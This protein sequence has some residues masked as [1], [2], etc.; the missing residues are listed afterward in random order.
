MRTVEDIMVPRN[1]IVGS[2]ST[3]TGIGSSSSCVSGQHT[4]LP[5]FTKGE[6]EPH[7]RRPQHESRSFMSWRGGGWT[8]RLTKRPVASEA[9]FVPWARQHSNC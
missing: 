4:R 5:V 1:E 9:Y 7:R 6:I 8:A 2:E 3:T